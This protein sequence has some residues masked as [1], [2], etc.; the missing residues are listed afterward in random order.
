MK[1]RRA[2]FFGALAIGLAASSQV[3]AGGSIPLP[4]GNFSVTVNGSESN[5]TSPT[6]CIQL[7][8]IEAGATVRDS[9]GNGCGTH[10]AV[11]AFSPPVQGPPIVVPV[12]HVFKVTSYAPA[13]GI[14]DQSLTE[15]S[16]GKC[17]GAIFDNAGATLSVTGT[18]HFVVSEG[19][20]RIDNVVTSLNFAGPSGPVPATN[21]LLT[22]TERAQ[23]SGQNQ[24]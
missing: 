13:T 16:G 3:M 15:Y 12:T 23:S 21:F 17:N 1:S 18:L 11:V 10:T 8:I 20:K 22:F 4:S 19:G 24:Q 14:G 7:N 5:C 9:A 6:S 2:M